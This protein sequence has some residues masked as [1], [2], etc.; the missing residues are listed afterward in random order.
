[1]CDN[2]SCTCE[3][4]CPKFRALFEFSLLILLLG[5][6]SS[7]AQNTI[8]V[9]PQFA[10]F[11]DSHRDII[12]LRKLKRPKIGLVLSGGGSRG[13][14]HVGVLKALEKNHIPIDLIVGTSIGGLVGGLYASG[15]STEQLQTLVDTTNWGEVLSFTDEADRTTMFVGQK[16][17]ADKN[18]L[19][20]R[21]DGLTPV[22]P[23]S[24]SSGQR[25]T[26]FINQLALQGIYHPNQSFD[27]L[28]IPFRAVATDLVS[29][30]RMV[31]ASGNLAEAL[32]ASITVPLLYST[33]KRD[34][35][36]LTDGGLISNIPVEVAC[37]MNMDIIIAVD[38]SSPLRSARQLNAPWEIADQIIGIMAQLAN[39]QSLEKATVVITPELGK[40]LAADFSQIDSLV[41][42][43]EYAATAAIPALRDSIRK[44]QSAHYYYG[45]D[46]AQLSFRISDVRFVGSA[47]PDSFKLDIQEL[48][49]RERVS[50]GLIKE[51]VSSLYALGDYRD[52]H[53]EIT[54][55]DSSASVTFVD[56]LNP[57]IHSIEVTGLSVV[58]KE[59]IEPLI[60]RVKERAV[61]SD[62]TRAALNNILALYRDKGYSLARI[63]SVQLDSVQGALR[64]GIDEGVI[65]HM[66]I[67]GTTKSRDWV[68]WRELPFAA[69]DVFTVSKGNQAIA[70]IM[71]TNLF[72]QV[73]LDVRYLDDKCDLV[74]KA[75][76]KNSELLRLGLRVDNER[77]V[78]PSIEIR[79]ENFLGTATEL[80]LNFAGGLRN[81]KYLFE[82][83]ANRI[84]NSF[85]TFNL[86]SY[87]DLRDIY[88]YADDPAI[89]SP[90]SFS[91][92]HIGEYRQVKYGASFS[93]GTQVQRLGLVT[94]EY[95]LEPNQTKFLNGIGYSIDTFT[96]QTLRLL[97]TIDTQD[98]FPF[99]R[100][101]SL[102]NISW[103]TASSVAAGDIGYSKIFLSYE[104]FSTYY[105]RHTLH[106][107]I[108]F[109]FADET[110]PLSQQFSLGGEN[111]FFGLFEDDSRGRQ[112]F[113]IN[114]EYR[115]ILPFRIL[116]DTYFK[117]R[118]DFGSIWPHQDN[119]KLKDL[120][121]GI[122]I[123]LAVDTPVGPASIAVGKSFYVRR[124]LLTEPL[125]LGPT[126]GYVSLGYQL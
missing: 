33:V 14:A 120:H 87:Y 8:L 104:W 48:T 13:V 52:V 30:K 34:S 93:L 6:P 61:N 44:K 109:G 67:E 78:Q 47:I 10:E 64:I 82:F 95:R 38:V 123:G 111:S 51:K 76:E 28:K 42:K 98:Q 114:V 66:S 89:Q 57:V 21:F 29:G 75:T 91:R 73:I 77:N 105:T 97:S 22:I 62:S 56:A 90:T 81:R 15:Y 113:V 106:P 107:K 7:Y 118:Y 83:R 84:F 112:I 32:R 39:K 16:Q 46:V 63:Q 100:S 110:L 43:G 65:F 36:Q 117:V 96:L 126:I 125:S 35:L 124:D 72:D 11:T 99:A 79:D 25:L 122:G 41:A 55:H 27:D 103:E 40:H 60:S 18:L 92:A 12:P 50:I 94:A 1:M 80:G 71:A 19:T 59:E 20:I 2:H 54:L 119:I 102:M 31:L 70:N 26:N 121:H 9:H 69:G 5:I 37:E 4:V 68:I 86:N 101:G 24:L 108:S 58:S 85:F 49:A 17:A 23:S 115:A 3:Y 45:P 74:I 116:W 88:T 53:A